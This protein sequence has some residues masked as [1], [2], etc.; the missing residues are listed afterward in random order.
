MTISGLTLIR[1]AIKCGYC[2]T[3]T[4]NCLDQISDE[5]IVMEGNSDDGTICILEELQAKNSKIK[6]I[7]SDWDL[8]SSDG[9]EFKR[10]T[11][12]GMKLCEGDYI[13]Y[14]QAD[15]IMHLEDVKEIPKNIGSHTFISFPIIHLRAGL[16]LA[17]TEEAI[18]ASKFYNRAVRFL[19][20]SPQ[21]T[22]RY[23]AY[24][25]WIEGQDPYFYSWQSNYPVFHMG[26]IVA[27][28]TCQKIINHSRYFYRPDTDLGRNLKHR[29]AIAFE[30]LCEIEKG[31]LND[32]E[33]WQIIFEYNLVA[34]G[35]SQVKPHSYKIPPEALQI[36]P[37]HTR[38]F[39]LG[40]LE[41]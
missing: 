5:I 41:W 28:T 34:Y 35:P 40:N 11:D 13:F 32:E 39:P 1:N 7:H 29:A 16:E 17:W 18:Q 4:I 26:Y 3:Q 10:I 15:E 14:L 27:K 30:I 31:T 19:K 6:I 20:N 8:K 37:Q 33:A 21:I 9:L 23:D 36:L 24:S 22:S 38:D 12:Q 25:F 2:I